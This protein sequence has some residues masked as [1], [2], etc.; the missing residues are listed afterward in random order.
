[1]QKCVFRVS[2]SRKMSK[3]SQQPFRLLKY[4]EICT[5]AIE[6][7]GANT[8]SAGDAQENHWIFL[9]VICIL[10]FSFILEY[11]TTFG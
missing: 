1:M 5:G 4:C 8:F 2:L 3:F 6:M 7:L 11:F 9:T 10:Q